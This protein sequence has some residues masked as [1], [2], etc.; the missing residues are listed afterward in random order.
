[1]I[2]FTK[3][4]AMAAMVLSI[5]TSQALAEYP[6]RQITMIV[7]FGAGGGSDRVARMVD[8]FWQ[9]STGKSFKFQYQ[10]GASGA[11]G[12]AAISRAKADGY[13]V[14]IVNMPNLVIQ[15][16][17]GTAT[18]KLDNFDY[19]GGVNFD[20]MVLMVP[21]S[22]PFKTLEEFIAAAKEAP[23]TFTIAITGSLSVGHIGALQF[24]EQAGIQVTLVPTQGGANTV[25]RVAGGHVTAG[26]IG[27]GLSTTQK[28]GRVLAVTSERRSKFSP[29]VPTFTEKGL[30]IVAAVKRV[31]VA[32]AGLPDDVKAY[33]RKN[34]S[35]VAKGDGFAKASAAQGLGA[36]W[37]SGEDLR[38]S[39][40]SM[41]ESVTKLLT[42]FKL[43]K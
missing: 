10:P 29:D 31:I 26:I 17:S 35:A 8:Q 18:F 33:L 5:G 22:S 28:S 25:A 40:F 21:E 27:L 41:E 13:T 20:P 9:E 36:E 37:Q 4:A 43:L 14:G 30:P 7:P 32:P 6:D 16:V 42:K 15:P 24:M 34:L 2:K 39:V 1:M 23:K 12:T 38:T 3:L 19:I 11:V